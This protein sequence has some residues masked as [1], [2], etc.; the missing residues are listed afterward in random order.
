MLWL[1]ALME[2]PQ[3]MTRYNVLTDPVVAVCR[4]RRRISQGW[5]HCWH[6]GRGCLGCRSWWSGYA[7]WAWRCGSAHGRNHGLIEHP[8]RDAALCLRSETGLQDLPALQ[9]DSSTTITNNIPSYYT[10]GGRFIDSLLLSCRSAPCQ[11]CAAQVSLPANNSCIPAALTMITTGPNTA[12]SY[13]CL[14]AALGGD[15]VHTSRSD[16]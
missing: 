6:R 7:L 8:A 12:S 15:I 14:H 4:R 5:P 3:H 1:P 16:Q 10:L 11:R 13:R 9:E 2:R